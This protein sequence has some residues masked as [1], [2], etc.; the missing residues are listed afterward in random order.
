MRRHCCGQI[1]GAIGLSLAAALLVGGGCGEP[2]VWVEEQRELHLDGKG[3]TSLA[4]FT[5]SGEVRVFPAITSDDSIE[6]VATVR[7]GGDS[8]AE[9]QENL[10]QLNV[11]DEAAKGSGGQRQVRWK[12]TAKPE[13]ARA[14]VSY[15]VHMPP[16]LE[17][18][19]D[20]HNGAIHVEGIRADCRLKT[21]NGPI[22]ANDVSREKFRAE[23]QN[24]EIEVRTAAEHVE[25]ETHNGAVTAYLNSPLE[26]GGSISTHNGGVQVHIG[27]DASA[28]LDLSTHNGTATAYGLTLAN[29]TSGRNWLKGRLGMG[30]RRLTLSSHNGSV[31]VKPIAMDST[32]AAADK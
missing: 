32:G 7:V 22:L 4:L 14:S 3:L 30:G 24:G 17:L 5:H 2:T 18:E 8:Q 19:V 6:L 16:T 27:S 20:T 11:Y 12:W 25:M 29:E 21:H 15:E 1:S 10:T 9:A 13:R 23:S 26:L 28:D 31:T